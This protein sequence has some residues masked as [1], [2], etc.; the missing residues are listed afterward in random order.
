MA[1][2]N[3]IKRLFCADVHAILDV[4]EEPEAILKQAI[5]EMQESLDWKRVRLARNRESLSSLKANQDHLK[6][7]IEKIKKDLELC[8]KEDSEELARKTLGRKLSLRKHLEAVEQRAAGLEKVCDQQSQEIEL[9]QDQLDSI[10]EKAMLYVHTAAEDSPSS[11]AESILSS[12]PQ[13]GSGFR[14]TEEEV[15]LEWMRVRDDFQKGGV[16]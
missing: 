13:T 14:V 6:G 10:L 16:S 2:T 11:V 3:R 7:E 15:E 4:I 1:I 8:L 5:R 9:Q 12:G